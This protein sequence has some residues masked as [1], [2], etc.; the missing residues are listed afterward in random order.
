M[1]L[2]SDVLDWGVP[3]FLSMDN[4]SR[5]IALWSNSSGGVLLGSLM[6]LDTAMKRPCCQR[7][8]VYSPAQP[9]E[10]VISLVGSSDKSALNA[11][12]GDER[13]LSRHFARADDLAGVGNVRGSCAV[14]ECLRIP[15]GGVAARA[16]VIGGQI[17]PLQAAV[18]PVFQETRSSW[19]AMES[20]EE[21]ALNRR[22]RKCHSARRKSFS[23]DLQKEMTMP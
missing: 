6:A 21:F 17:P 9:Q 15:T 7:G 16:G 14:P 22:L 23:P 8:R 12:V 19:R 13:G 20:V 2:K 3:R 11:C 4:L 10:P 1:E 18:L 5:A